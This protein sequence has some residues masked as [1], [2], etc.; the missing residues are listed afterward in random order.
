MKERKVPLRKCAG[1]GESKPKKELVRV[2]R[3]PDGTVSID[4]RGKSPG[5]GAYVCPNTICLQKALRSKA[6]DRSLEVEI[7]QEIYE[8]LIAQMEASRNE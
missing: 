4:S 6:L 5:R 8:T 7:P 3:A 1:C 2:V